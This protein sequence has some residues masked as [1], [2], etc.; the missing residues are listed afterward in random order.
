MILKYTFTDNKLSKVDATM[1]P[2]HLQDNIKLEF[3]KT[4]G[5]LPNS[6]YYANVKTTDAIKRVRLRK[7]KD[8]YTCELPK[9]V[10]K[11]AFFKLQVDTFIEDKHFSTNELIIPVNYLDYLDYN[12][13]IANNFKK[14]KRFNCYGKDFKREQKDYDYYKSLEELLIRNL[15]EKGVTTK[16]TDTLKDLIEKIKEIE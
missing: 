14:P 5:S 3:T 13:T 7:Y 8:K 15:E 2:Q 9:W 6:K 11:Y 12:R 10:T 16:K 1:Y 4:D